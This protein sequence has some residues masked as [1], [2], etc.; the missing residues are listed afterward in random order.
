MMVPGM[1][2]S[3]GYTGMA[4][5]DLL[6]QAK[7]KIQE[8]LVQR[9]LKDPW[10]WVRHAT[11]TRDEQ[12]RK[13]PNKPFPDQEYIR[14]CLEIMR[15]EPISYY[16]KSRTMMLTWTLCAHR[17][18][19]GFT[20]PQ[21]RHVF[22]G[23]D[24]R[25]AI[26]CI[27]YIKALWENSLPELKAL[28]PLKKDMG[29]QAKHM[30]EME[31]G[32]IFE[33]LAGGAN[34]VRSLH[35]TTYNQDE[36]AFIEDGADCL[37]EAMAANP[38][39]VILVSSANPGWFRDATIDAIPEPSKVGAMPQGMAFRRLVSGEAV[40]RV[41]YTADTNKRGKWA[42]LQKLKFKKKNNWA[43]EMEM[44]YDAKNGTLVYPDFDTSVHVV[45]DKE[46]PTSGCL[47]MAA[48]P[49]PRTPHAFLWVLIDRFGDWWVYRELWPSKSYG[50]AEDVRDGDPECLFTTRQY[51]EALAALEGNRLTFTAHADTT[52]GELTESGERIYDRFMDQAGKAF[53][54]SAEGTPTETFWT[55]YS[56]YGYSFKEPYKIHEAG[57]DRI[58]ELLELAPHENGMQPRLHV[59]RSCRELILEFQRYRYKT[60]S[61]HM[62]IRNEL[63]QKGIDKRCHL[64]DCL[65]YIA[66]SN[67]SYER[68]FESERYL[69]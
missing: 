40:V 28:W 69:P 11:K 54:V 10:I 12:D 58:H 23:P 56:Q 61:D 3:T 7:S 48:D 22:H 57:E 42:N 4:A 62:S 68:D 27:N 33:A 64:L 26:N 13:N 24:E 50:K 35:P 66:T 14:I 55:R 51:C 37:D 31:N 60:I 15:A 32:T 2:H 16:E 39:S 25:R 1:P 34:K 53:T 46:I 19:E 9:A 30:L 67:A 63:S 21:Q 5:A 18:H 8:L 65:R 38:L 36:S 17:A 47:F 41:H 44:E 43:Q 29:L 45:D 49:H 52:Y 59:A 20:T 6:E